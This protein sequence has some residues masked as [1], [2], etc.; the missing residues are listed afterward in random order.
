MTPV[1]AASLLLVVILG[2]AGWGLHPPRAAAADGMEW[3]FNEAND[4]DNKGAMTARLIYG[5]PETDNIQVSGV[6]DAR[7]STSVKFSSVT[8]GADIGDLKDGKDT[9]LRFSGGGFDHA[10]K[11][12][13]YRAS[14]EE[15]LS[16][17]HVDIEHDDPLW[18]AMGEKQSLDYLVP[19]Y[20]AASLDLTRGRDKIKQFVQACRT[21]AQAVGGAQA[22]EAAKDADDDAEKD[23][24]DSAKEV[25]TIEAWNAFIA[26]YPSGFHADLARAYI[27][28]LSAAASPSAP[29]PDNGVTSLTVTSVRYAKGAFVKNGPDSWVEQGE[30]GSAMFRFKET[31]RDGREVMLFDPSRKVVISLRLGTGEILY[32]PQGKPLAKLYDIID[33]EGGYVAPAIVPN[34]SASREVPDPPC[35]N[36]K[37]IRS[38]DSAEATKLTIINK[39]GAMRGVLRLDY[40][41]HPKDYANLSSGEQ[42]VLETF[43]THPWM[44]TDGPGNCLQIVMPHPGARVVELGGGEAVKPAAVAPLKP[45]VKAKK[46]GCGKG[47]IT[48]D[49]KCMS[50]SQAV[51]Y[52]GPGYRP[53]GGKC[54]QG[55]VAPKPAQPRCKPGLVWS[56]QEGCHEDD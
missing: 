51:G 23:A 55:F 27:K 4:P 45:A 29:P 8:F 3:Q 10:L 18:S 31:S 9:E 7:P 6:C 43:T 33:S 56:P 5:V 41:G 25:G 38:M 13:I 52:C 22:N 28:K 49:G 54:V 17:V 42:V 24:F 44:I 53:Q 14:G 30:N 39:S 2:V 21:Y 40:S 11:G 36:R 32:G 16:G 50:K 12:Q 35:R 48:V 34:V 1:R 20:K 26:N 37:N 15:G 46:S 19:G 47:Q